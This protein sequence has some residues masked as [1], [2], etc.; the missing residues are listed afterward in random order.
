MCSGLYNPA[1]FLSGRG[2]RGL[3]RR[4]GEGDVTTAQE[5]RRGVASKYSHEHLVVITENPTS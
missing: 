5:G 1:E 4:L 3:E 2:W